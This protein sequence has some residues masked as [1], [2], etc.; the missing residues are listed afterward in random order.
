MFTLA[1]S[2]L[3]LSYTTSQIESLKREA[4]S[5]STQLANL[6]SAGSTGRAFGISALPFFVQ[7]VI[8][9]GN[10]LNGSVGNS[11]GIQTQ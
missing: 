2:G 9:E 3:S 4:S 7:D 1:V 8:D 10:Y 5:I 11:T 6:Q